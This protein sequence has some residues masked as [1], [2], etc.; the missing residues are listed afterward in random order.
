MKLNIKFISILL[1]IAVVVII[2]ANIEL[3]V[4][5]KHCALSLTLSKNSNTLLPENTGFEDPIYIY[6]SKHVKRKDLIYQPGYVEEEYVK[7]VL[8]EH[9]ASKISHPFKDLTKMVSSMPKSRTPINDLYTTLSK[10]GEIINTVDPLSF[11]PASNYKMLTSK[12]DNAEA[13]ISGDKLY[14]VKK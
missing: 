11:D 3:Y 6:N 10:G 7:K 1:V 5:K 2:L 13:F 4:N 14:I 8:N 12:R 9:V